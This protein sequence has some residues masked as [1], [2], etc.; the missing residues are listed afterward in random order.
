MTFFRD[1]FY[2]ELSERDTGEFPQMQPSEALD[3][4]DEAI[5]KDPQPLIT[6]LQEVEPHCL[7]SRSFLISSSWRLSRLR[8]SLQARTETL[9]AIE[10]LKKDLDPAEVQEI[11]TLAKQ[12]EVLCSAD[13]H[14]SRC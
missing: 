3:M 14:S 13:S 9:Q 6:P 5:R 7:Y 10:E 1:I 12:M 4:L 11:E 2:D 8:D